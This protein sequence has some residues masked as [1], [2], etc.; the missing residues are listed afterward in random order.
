VGA[1]LHHLD[2]FPAPSARSFNRSWAEKTTAVL[3]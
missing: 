2:R 1:L 3:A